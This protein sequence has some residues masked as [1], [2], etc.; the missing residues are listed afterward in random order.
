MSILLLGSPNSY[1][2]EVYE[3]IFIMQNGQET[4]C[5][6]VIRIITAVFRASAAMLMRC[7]LFW[8]VTW[9]RMLIVYWRFGT[10]HQC[11]LQGSKYFWPLKMVPIH[12]PET[13]VDDYHTTPRNTP[14]E[15]RSQLLQCLQTFANWSY[16][17]FVLSTAL[18]HNL[19]S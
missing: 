3:Y 7:A 9:R 14:E 12:C 1:S 19:P 18:I 2:Y 11:H 4:P 15:R 10:R 5:L 6:Y 13:S 16:S 8:G 17:Q